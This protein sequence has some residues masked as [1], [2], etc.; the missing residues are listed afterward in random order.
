MTA[1]DLAKQFDNQEIIKLLQ[2]AGALPGA[3]KKP[4]A[5][6]IKPAA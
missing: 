3:P 5:G 2:S 1:L 4:G 6:P